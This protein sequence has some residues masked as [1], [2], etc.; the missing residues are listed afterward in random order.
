MAALVVLMLTLGSIALQVLSDFSWQL[1]RTVVD[2]W[3]AAG[4]APSAV[5]GVLLRLLTPVTGRLT[6]R[7]LEHRGRVLVVA[8][9]AG[10]SDSL[11]RSRT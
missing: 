9:V 6:S 11:A 1:T 2:R 3:L 4:L 7:Y 8:A 5:A 10:S